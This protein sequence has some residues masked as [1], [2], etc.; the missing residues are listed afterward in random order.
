MLTQV[1]AMGGHRDAALRELDEAEAAYR[2][3]D[4][5]QDVALVRRLRELIAA[6]D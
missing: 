1:L 2:K 6:R 3:L 4:D 5:G